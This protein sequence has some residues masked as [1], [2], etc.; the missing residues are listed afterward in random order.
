MARFSL[1]FARPPL[2]KG[3]IIM[4]YTMFLLCTSPPRH[5]DLSGVYSSCKWKPQPAATGID[6]FRLESQLQGDTISMNGAFAALV[7][8]TRDSLASRIEPDILAAAMTKMN[9]PEEVCHKIDSA[10]SVSEIF[11]H[12]NH[13]WSWFNYHLLEEIIDD[14]GDQND[15][16]RLANYTQKFAE[17]GKKRVFELPSD[18]FQ[19][20]SF[21]NNE[22]EVELTVKVDGNLEEYCVKDADTFCSTLASVLGVRRHLLRLVSVRDG[23]VLLTFLIPRS[24]AQPAFSLSISQMTSLRDRG[25]MELECDGYQQSL[26]RR[27]S[28]HVCLFTSEDSLGTIFSPCLLPLVNLAPRTD[29]GGS[30]CVSVCLLPF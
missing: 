25:V 21:D 26:G 14:L 2:Y 19:R 6:L 13:S 15:H 7:S 27:V 12:V 28:V 30:L 16:E 29:G 9:L 18:A 3:L 4:Y 1:H 10:R 8:K 23:C 11:S 17:Y 20:A 22:D 24:M 5:A